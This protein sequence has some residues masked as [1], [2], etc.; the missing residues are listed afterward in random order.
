MLVFFAC[1][2]LSQNSVP[3]HRVMGSDKLS[4]RKRKVWEGREHL[5]TQVQKNRF[6]FLARRGEKNLGWL[7]KE[8]GK[9]DLQNIHHMLEF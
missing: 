5:N 3:E 7:R 8:E 9:S 1:N 6:W 2:I 4:R